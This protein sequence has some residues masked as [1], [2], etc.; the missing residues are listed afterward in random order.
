MR[1][2]I[3][4]GHRAATT[5]EFSLNDLPGS[6]GRMDLLTRSV[7]SGFCISHGIRR[8]VEVALVLLGPDDPPK[9]IRLVGSELKYLNPDERSTGAL[10]RNALIK[11]NE[12]NKQRKIEE[13]TQS[14]SKYPTSKKNALALAGELLSSPG[15]YI[16]NNGLSEVLKH[17]SK[18]SNIMYIH[19]NGLDISGMKFANE[20]TFVLS[21]DKDFTD[22]E[23]KLIK[24]YAESEISLG[25]II[26][27]T[28]HCISII[29]NYLDRV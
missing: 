1:N 9:T 8:D 23:E 15:I 2:F 24:D 28:D 25:P 11:I 3:I 10:I 17:Y 21:D 13:T 26:I 16:S 14:K 6:A 29:H 5:P 27:H 12:K 19:E 18:K 22:D 7:S 4:I 20:C